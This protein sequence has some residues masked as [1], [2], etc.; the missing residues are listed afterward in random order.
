MTYSP[1]VVFPRP[2]ALV[3]SVIAERVVMVAVPGD[4]IDGEPESTV[5]QFGRYRLVLDGGVVEVEFDGSGPPRGPVHAISVGRRRPTETPVSH[6][7]GGLRLRSDARDCRTAVTRSRDPNDPSDRSL[8]HSPTVDV[9][10]RGTSKHVTKSAETGFQVIRSCRCS[11]RSDV[12][13]APRARSR[14]PGSS[15]RGT[16]H[17]AVAPP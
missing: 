17:R 4:R 7:P 11:F 15:I 14:R 1:R 8:S 16:R 3:A 12:L 5:G 13:T 10:E 2:R 6:L 9:G